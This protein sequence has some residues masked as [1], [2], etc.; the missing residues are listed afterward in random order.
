[1]GAIETPHLVRSRLRTGAD[2]EQPGVRLV[3]PALILSF[4]RREKG[5]FVGHWDH[6]IG[7]PEYLESLPCNRAM[8][9][10]SGSGSVTGEEFPLLQGE[11]Q[12]E[13]QTKPEYQITIAV[14]IVNFNSGELLKRCLAA[15]ND[16]RRAPDR[17]VVVDNASTD[18]SL[19]EAMRTHSG[20]EVVQLESNIGFA[21]ANN[22]GMERCTDCDYVALLNPDAFPERGWLEALANAAEVLPEAGSF[23][24]CL[25][26]AD[27]QDV[28]DGVGDAYHVSG[29]V[30]RSGHGE[31][32][33]PNQDRRQVF[34]PCA[35]A[36]L[37]RR[38]AVQAVGAFDESYF[39]YN[40]DVD[41]GFRLR[42]RGL[43]CWY[44]PD[45]MV[46]HV[47]SAVTGSH[48]DFS[49]FHGHRNLVWTYVKN[50]PGKLMA[51]FLWQHV[52]LNLVSVVALSIRYRTLAVIRSK[53]SALGG[54]KRA[55]A[56][57]RAIQAARSCSDAELLDVMVRGWWRCY[58]NR[59][60]TG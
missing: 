56:Q 32:V 2:A 31:P 19:S 16:Q 14:I 28:L 11:G 58:F 3:I 34:A 37:Y 35:A 24:S 8:T 33:P 30:W 49:L 20:I 36:A 54:M 27:D 7:N 47:G 43:A 26:K 41:L 5:P 39:C 38:E 44:V 12:G 17:V 42:L 60:L 40:E 9:D 1:M 57:R 15:L 25:V 48:S 55:L 29:L 10:G 45:A 46:R 4:S 59:R 23:A 50:M 21:G 13:G 53:W 6:L 52:L 18:D 22:R 51:R